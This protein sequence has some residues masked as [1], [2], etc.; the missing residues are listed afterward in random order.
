M[1][2]KLFQTPLKR[3]F[4][5]V[6]TS[7]R[8]SRWVCPS[9]SHYEISWFSWNLQNPSKSLIFINFGHFAEYDHIWRTRRHRTDQIMLKNMEFYFQTFS[10]ASET[11]VFEGKT[12]PA[13]LPMGIPVM[14]ALW[15]F[16]NIMK[17][18]KSTKILDFHQFWSFCWI[19]PHLE[20]ST[21]P[22]RPDNVEK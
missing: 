17:S 4:S 8:N 3:T 2:F 14:I 12:L 21:T 18:P 13:Q 20:N 11:R 22:N 15:D 1:R 9:W 6:K 16:M 10:N 5:R 19:W 7:P